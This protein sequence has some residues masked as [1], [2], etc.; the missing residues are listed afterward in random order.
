MF[1]FKTFWIYISEV[2]FSVLFTIAYGALP[3][4]RAFFS[5]KGTVALTSDYETV[6]YDEGL[7]Y[8]IIFLIVGTL[9]A[10]S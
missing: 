10:L 8:S 7:K 6:R 2:I 9:H 5:G 4:I 1:Y 3:V